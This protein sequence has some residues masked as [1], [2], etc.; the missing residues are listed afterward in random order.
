MRLARRV[1]ADHRE[2]NL[3]WFDVLQPFAAGDQFAVGRKNRG[4][5]NDVASRDARIAQRKLKAR[6]P[7][8]M[9]PDTFCE[10]NLFRDERH[11]WC[12]SAVPPKVCPRF[13]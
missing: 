10:E 11:V 1:L 5:A 2:R 3:S 12:R 6:E 13:A 7:L 4:H 8:A 9:F